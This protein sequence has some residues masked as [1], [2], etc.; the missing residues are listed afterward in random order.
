MNLDAFKENLNRHLEGVSKVMGSMNL[1][2]DV[3]LKNIGKVAVVSALIT[4]N[5]GQALAQTY[6]TAPIN[7]PAPIVNAMEIGTA[8]IDGNTILFEN[9]NSTITLNAENLDMSNDYIQSVQAKV[10]HF[11]QDM[12]M[13]GYTGAELNIQ[14][15]IA[16]PVDGSEMKLSGFT[17]AVTS[18]GDVVFNV[19]D[20][21]SINVDSIGLDNYATLTSAHA[22]SKHFIASNVNSYEN[23]LL[24][25]LG[26][27]SMRSFVIND[28]VSDQ[29]SAPMMEDIAAKGDNISD[30]D[31]N[32]YSEA[33]GAKVKNDY[34]VNMEIGYG[35]SMALLMSYQ[36]GLKNASMSDADLNALKAETMDLSYKIKTMRGDLASEKDSPALAFHVAVTNM[37]DNINA[38]KYDYNM[39]PNQ[40]LSE[41]VSVVNEATPQNNHFFL[42]N[43]GSQQNNDEYNA[44]ISIKKDRTDAYEFATPLR[45]GRGAQYDYAS[46]LIGDFGDTIAKSQSLSADKLSEIAEP[47][48]VQQVAHSTQNFM[49]RAM[50]MG[51]LFSVNENKADQV[52]SSVNIKESYSNFKKDAVN[53][54]DVKVEKGHSFM[55]GPPGA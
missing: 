11:Y 17:P 48:I 44:A 3:D 52:T 49:G 26:E 2:R 30:Y 34:L 53:K 16:S 51:G 37:A 15:T 50:G 8:S 6:S 31:F 21:S 7:E 1:L 12:D 47:S 40:M 33:F 24:N 41:V 35:D 23:I 28:S 46:K 32:H 54:L 9:A 29:I 25:S 45:T 22:I 20:G 36:D 13:S 10:G 14:G 55:S 43:V 27:D 42:K 38:G 18:Q 4:A 5:A 39:T 19:A